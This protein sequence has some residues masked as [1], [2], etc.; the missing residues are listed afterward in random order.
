MHKKIHLQV[1]TDRG[2][3]DQLLSWFEQLN[4]PPLEDTNVWCQCQILLLEAFSNVVDHAHKNLPADTPIDLEA[5]RFSHSIEIRIWS[6]GEPFNLEQKLRELP[7]FEENQNERGRGLKIMSKI[8]D[9]LSY[10]RA[11]DD[12]NCL[13]IM[14]RY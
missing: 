12:R 13:F 6:L 11:R 3:S 10:D 9:D 7:E 8:A 4:Q 5:S 14:K 2:A 1:K